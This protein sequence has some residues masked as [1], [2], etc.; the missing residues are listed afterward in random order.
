MPFYFSYIPSVDYNIQVYKG[1]NPSSNTYTSATANEHGV[2]TND[3]I[4]PSV[5]NITRRFGL[6]QV[7]E[8]RKASFYNYL[9][10]EGERPDMI[11]HRYYDDATLDWIIWLTNDIHDPYFQWPMD[12]YTFDLYIR[13]KYGSLREAQAN[14]YAYYQIITQQETLPTGKTISE[15]KIEVDETTYN[16]LGSDW[17]TKLNNYEW[18]NAINEKRRNIV[19]L[20]RDFIPDVLKKCARM[21][22]NG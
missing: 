14:T 20:E 6:E 11:A 21:T 19:I 12:T 1:A 5:V 3:Q 2:A 18:E 13:D 8:A 9:I 22:F 7:I 17:R 16:G 4:I 15:R 10:D